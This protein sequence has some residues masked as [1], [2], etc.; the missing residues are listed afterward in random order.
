MRNFILFIIIIISCTLSLNS[1]VTSRLTIYSG[2]A[3]NFNFQ[4]LDHYQNG[5]SYINW[6]HLTVFFEDL[7][8]PLREWKL[9][10]EAMTPNIQGDA[11]NLLPLNTI[12]FEISGDDPLAT[13]NNNAGNAVLSQAPNRN[14]VENGQQTTVPGILT[15]LFISWHCGKSVYVPNSL[16]GSR[17]DYYYVEVMF[18]LGPE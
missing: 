9:S 12:E 8:D 15:N 16:I 17:S 14:L 11:G 4:L 5:V 2:D 7:G 6:T 18:T 13:Y 10:V 3:V 1:Q